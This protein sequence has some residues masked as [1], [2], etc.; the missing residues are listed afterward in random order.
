M[1]RP[2]DG[3]VESATARPTR[4]PRPVETPRGRSEPIRGAP[5]PSGPGRCG[6]PLVLC[7][8]RSGRAKH[9]HR[10]V[11]MRGYRNGYEKPA[12]LTMRT[13][14]VTAHR[15]RV[16]DVA[17]TTDVG[18]GKL[19]G[20]LHG[21]AGASSTGVPWRGGLPAPPDRS[22]VDPVSVR[23]GHYQ[24]LFGGPPNPASPA[25]RLRSLGWRRVVH[26]RG[27]HSR[28]RVRDGRRPA[29]VGSRP[30]RSPQSA[31]R[32]RPGTRVLQRLPVADRQ[33]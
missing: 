16:R 23:L 19:G 4:R 5:C 27:G 11:D 33:G 18:S 1:R 7:R 32:F 26:A 30:S 12:G 20:Q 13:G 22:R 24:H 2:P 28:S 21:G 31:S 9:Q 14:T 10:G 8:S 3:R 15:P 17:T 6:R 25:K 29:A